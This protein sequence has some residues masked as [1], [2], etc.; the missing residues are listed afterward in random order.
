MKEMIYGDTDQ[1]LYLSMN[2]REHG[3]DGTMHILEIICS[4]H[5]EVVFLEK[6]CGQLQKLLTKVLIF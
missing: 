6:R 2:L 3:L 5:T 4:V 1:G